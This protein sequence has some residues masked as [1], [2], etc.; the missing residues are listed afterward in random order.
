MDTAVQI[1]KN[2]VKADLEK[3]I[4]IHVPILSTADI[5]Y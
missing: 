5:D 4:S 3:Q 2:V 1:L